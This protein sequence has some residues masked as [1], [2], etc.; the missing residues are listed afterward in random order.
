MSINTTS[1]PRERTDF[2]TEEA[3]SRIEPTRRA[4]IEEMLLEIPISARRN[5]LRAA[6]GKAP[7]RNAIKAFCLQCAGWDR[8]EIRRCTA[9]ACPLYSYRPF[10]RS[11]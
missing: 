7:P 3:L 10:G 8:N 2:S 4:S 11:K 1:K 6:V 9:V 5:Y